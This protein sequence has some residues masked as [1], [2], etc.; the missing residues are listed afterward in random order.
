MPIPVELSW[1]FTWGVGKLW[2]ESCT[3][4]LFKFLFCAGHP[5]EQA[6]YITKCSS[7]ENV[8]PEPERTWALNFMTWLKEGIVTRFTWCPWDAKPTFTFQTEMPGHILTCK[9]KISMKWIEWHS[10]GWRDKVS[11]IQQIINLW[12]YHLALLVKPWFSHFA[13][14]GWDDITH[15]S[16][17]AWSELSRYDI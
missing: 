4:V 1:S 10:L 13:L 15:W 14:P 6:K 17:F 12:S 11:Y 8:T 7:L 3:S 5:R 16:S 9:F 2:A